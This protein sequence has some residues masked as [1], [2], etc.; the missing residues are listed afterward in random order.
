MI[1]LDQN[2]LTTIKAGT[3]NGL[4]SLIRLEISQNQITSIES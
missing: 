1:D 2:K 4:S 3:F